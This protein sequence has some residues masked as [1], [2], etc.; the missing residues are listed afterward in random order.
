MYVYVYVV[1]N[2]CS[3]LS[4][5]LFDL[6]LFSL[7]FACLGL[8]REGGGSWGALRRCAQDEL[9]R[10]VV[11]RADIEQAGLIREASRGKLGLKHI[12]IYIYVCLSMYIYIYTYT[13]CVYIYIYI[14]NMCVYVCV[15]IYIYIYTN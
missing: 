1:S 5:H 6:N 4:L 12:Y 13:V 2:Y 8:S 3:S 9:G 7:F 10:A 15:Y 14:Y 11:A